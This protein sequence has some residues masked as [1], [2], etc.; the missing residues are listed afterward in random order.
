MLDNADIVRDG[1]WLLKNSFLAFSI[2]KFAR[3]LL[4]VRSPLALKFTEITALV[5]FSTPT[6]YFNNNRLEAA[7]KVRDQVRLAACASRWPFCRK[8]RAKIPLR[9]AHGAQAGTAYSTATWK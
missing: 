6:R 8:V 5:P 7:T 2:T 1:E 4:N 9:D 3:K